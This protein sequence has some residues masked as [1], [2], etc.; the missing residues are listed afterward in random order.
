[1]PACAAPKSASAAAMLNTL[2]DIVAVYYKMYNLGNVV[3]GAPARSD[4]KL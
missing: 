1:M 3:H 2:R 4:A